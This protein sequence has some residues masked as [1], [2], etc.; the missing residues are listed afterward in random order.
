[1]SKARTSIAA[2]LCV[3]VVT[4]MTGGAQAQLASGRSGSSTLT[5]IDQAEAMITLN[6]FGRC[7]AKKNRDDALTLIAT[8][9]SSPQERQTIRSLFKRDNIACMSS[10]T[11][12]RMPIPY[13]RGVIVE[14]LVRAGMGVPASH[15]LPVASAAD[16]RNVSD[17]A[18]CYV[19]AHRSDVQNLMETKPASK[20]EFE[21]VSAI[22]GELSKCLS[23]NSPS[24]LDAT[25]VRYRLIEALLRLQPPA[26]VQ[27]EF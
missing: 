15:V 21:A 27:P 18:R 24:E 8:R 14:G 4:A 1:M 23:S 9:P 2:T 17:A 13:V 22:M 3:A 16:V 10:D 12:L 7:Y 20:K 6:W 11:N 19:P 26:S 25:L 5:Y